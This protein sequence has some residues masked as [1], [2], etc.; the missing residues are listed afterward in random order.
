MSEALRGMPSLGF[1]ALPAPAKVNLF[2]HVVEQRADGYHELQTGFQLIDLYDYLSF[3]LRD[4]GQIHVSMPS[5]SV[6]LEDNL[7][8]QAARRLQIQQNVPQ[9][10]D[11]YCQKNIP[12]G[13]GLGGG[14]SNAATTLIALNRLWGTGLT[15]SELMTLGLKLGADVPVFIFGRPAFAQGVGEQLEATAAIQAQIA[16]FYPHLFVSTKEVFTHPDLTRDT[17]RIN[18]LSF[19]EW[20]KSQSGDAHD[21]VG[22]F[23]RNDL[24][25]VAFKLHPELEQLQACLK[26]HGVD[27]KLSGSGSSLFALFATPC[28]SIRQS[29]E[30]WDR[31]LSDVQARVGTDV[32]FW[33]CNSLAEHPL[34]TWLD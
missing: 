4:D 13:A 22:S 3:R 31:I 26:M 18:M 27:V 29:E 2:L 11:I 23:G 12:A 25:P 6:P 15:R 30:S 32:Q 33:L 24:Q 20:L 14:S 7:I 10:V 9:G 17:K 16:L 21:G 19:T 8:Y 5:S 28:E 34:N 1:A